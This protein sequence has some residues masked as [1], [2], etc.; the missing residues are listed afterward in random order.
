MNEFDKSIKQAQ[1]KHLKMSLLVGFIILPVAI[2]ITLWLLFAKGYNIVVGPQRAAESATYSIVA[3]FGLF[4]ENKLYALT[5]D[6]T[7]ETMAKG[8]ITHTEALTETSNGTVEIIMAPK[9][10]RVSATTALNLPEVA[11]Y[12]D[13]KL[14]LIDQQFKAELQPGLHKIKLD[15]SYHQPHTEKFL[16]D[17]D[18]E[19]SWAFQLTPIEGQFTIDSKPQGAQVAL[20]GDNVGVTPLSIARPGGEYQLSVTKAGYKVTTET[21]ELTNLAG[22]AT[23]DYRLI[24]KDAFVVFSLR[25]AGGSFLLDGKQI[26]VAEQIILTANQAHLVLYEKPGFY[27]YKQSITLKPGEEKT[28]DIKLKQEIGKVVLESTPTA[29][30]IVNGKS[31]GQSPVIANFPAIVHKVQFKKPGYR[32]IDKQMTPSAK[33]ATLIDVNILTEY[34]A[35]RQEGKPTVASKMGIEMANFKPDKVTMGSKTNER[36]RRRNEFVI[37]VEFTRAIAVSRH[38]ISER[39]Y[40]QFRSGQSKSDLP[41][42]DI[43]WIEA[44]EFCNWLSVK[45]GLPVFYQLSGG[46][47]QGV[48]AQSKGYRLPTEAEWEWLARRAKRAVETKYVW[49]NSDRI[50]KEVANLGDESGKVQNVFFLKGYDDSHP[51]KA[52]VGSFKVDRAGLHDLAGNVSEWVHDNYSNIPP[53]GNGVLQDPLGATRGSGHLYK[54]GSYASGRLTELRPAYR[55]PSA[56]KAPTIGFRIARYL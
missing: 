35:R 40:A 13:G 53:K 8:Y 34:A 25:P 48:N 46:R 50:P 43:S 3:G 49:G 24:P 10:G 11:W 47:Y 36:G 39:Q 20:N 7:F 32:T 17:N 54:G 28:I 2:L 9:P 51:G 22:E 55:E 33:S 6:T 44:V 16:I 21:V 45:E 56:D 31:L 18:E 37:N 26:S 14:M 29:E 38:E 41:V 1:K 19:K 15:S 42:S 52:P 23:R 12:L 4:H 5:S 30:V 27:P